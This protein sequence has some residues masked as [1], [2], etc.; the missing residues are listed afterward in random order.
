MWLQPLRDPQSSLRL[1]LSSSTCSDFPVETVEFLNSIVGEESA[2][3]GNSLGECLDKIEES[4]RPA[5]DD[6]P[7]RRLRLLQRRAAR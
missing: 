2:L 3:F 7:L 6:E 4:E 1:L 5:G